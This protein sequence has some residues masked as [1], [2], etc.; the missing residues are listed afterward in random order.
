MA[1]TRTAW[2]RARLALAACLACG[3]VWGLAGCAAQAPLAGP[4]PPE[5]VLVPAGGFVM[6]GE[7]SP[8]QVVAKGGGEE[9]YYRREHPQHQVRISQAFYL[10]VAPVTNGQFAAFVAATGYRTQAEQTG[11]GMVWRKGWVAVP[12]ADWRHP[13]GPESGIEGRDGHPVVQV[14]W[15]DAQAY[16][17][18][19]SRALGRVFTLPNE[20]QWEYACR[21]G[22]Q[23]A[24]NTGDTITTD[25]ANYFGRRPY[26]G[27]PQG[28]YRQDTTPAGAF[29]P[30]AWGLRDMHG[31]VWQWCADW[32]QED[33][34]QVSPPEDP[35][36]PVQG[37]ERVVRG[38]AWNLPAEDIRCARRYGRPPDQG[39][40]LVGLRLASPGPSP[41][42]P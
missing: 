12:G 32:Y 4:Q 10:Q 2:Q 8:A 7:D 34:Y 5:M 15:Q 13:T 33:Y 24:F 11:Q 28:V 31:N 9:K 37:Q 23:S 14:S 3:L 30:N 1:D 22:G 18:W 16:C 25:Q 26:A 27:G 6:G 39:Y 21:A 29:A 42:N 40:N 35:P 41:S 19:L 36:G 17:A 20:A 38:G